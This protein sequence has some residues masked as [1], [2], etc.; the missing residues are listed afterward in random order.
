MR[1]RTNRRKF[2]PGIES[3]CLRITPTDFTPLP[4]VD[5]CPVIAEDGSDPGARP[6][7]LLLDPSRTLYPTRTC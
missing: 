5:L 7:D 4:P 2:Q 3:L 6:D 1:I